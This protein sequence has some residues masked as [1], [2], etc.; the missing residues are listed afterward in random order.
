MNQY[1]D[2]AIKGRRSGPRELRAGCG[3]PSV[4][5]L[6]AQGRAARQGAGFKHFPS[7]DPIKEGVVHQLRGRR[8]LLLLFSR[9]QGRLKLG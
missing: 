7:L 5:A 1:L 6:A 8:Q 2:A 9:E 3:K 4:G